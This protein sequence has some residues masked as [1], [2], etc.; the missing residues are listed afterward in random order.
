VVIPPLNAKESGVGY[1]LLH[2]EVKLLLWCLKKPFPKKKRKK[3]PL[4]R[5]PGE[6]WAT[7]EK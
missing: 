4:N 2:L 7:D 3:K 1:W 5:K 6:D